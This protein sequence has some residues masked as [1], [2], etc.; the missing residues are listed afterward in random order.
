MKGALLV[1]GGLAVHA[2][3][4]EGQEWTM[5][6]DWAG[7]DH[8]D[9]EAFC[10][11][12]S[13]YL[14]EAV[15]YRECRLQDNLHDD[16]WGLLDQDFSNVQPPKGDPRDI[17]DTANLPGWWYPADTIPRFVANPSTRLACDPRLVHYAEDNAEFASADEV[18]AAIEQDPEIWQNRTNVSVIIIIQCHT[19][20]VAKP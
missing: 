6:S 1:I 9:H 12:P 16:S 14:A 10:E 11:N 5:W 17:I 2:E 18:E 3:N 20:K 13:N 4:P 8:L 7:C 15:R 19:L